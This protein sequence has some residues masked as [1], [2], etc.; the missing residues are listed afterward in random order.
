MEKLLAD[1]RLFLDERALPLES[2]YLTLPYSEVEPRLNEL[3]E[4]VKRRGLWA[5]HL[6][7][8]LAGAGFRSRNSRRSP[9]CWA[10]PRSATT[11]ST[12]RRR[13]SATAS[14]SILME[15]LDRKRNGWS[16]SRAARS[17]AVSR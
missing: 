5:P 11:S 13:T 6:P 3:R 10:R 7:V 4:E 2:A 15:V 1:I 8:A 14:C 17:A 16:R 9:R 12:R